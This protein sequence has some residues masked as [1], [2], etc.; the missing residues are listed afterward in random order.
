ML[1]VSLNPYQLTIRESVGIAHEAQ[2]IEIPVPKSSP[3]L[4]YLRD[5]SSGRL[6]PVQSSQQQPG[7]GYLLLSIDPDQVLSHPERN[8][9]KKARAG[10]SPVPSNGFAKAAVRGAAG[11]TLIPQKGR[12]VKKRPGGKK[13][14]CGRFT[15]IASNSAKA[16]FTNWN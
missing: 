4:F 3:P 5:E 10:L 2:V 9:S 7:R 11:L 14:R 16:A 8:S 13:V 12:S 6:Y 1:H 15:T